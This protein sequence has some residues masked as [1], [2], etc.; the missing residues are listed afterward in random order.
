MAEKGIV[1][2]KPIRAKKSWVLGAK[3]KILRGSVG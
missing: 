1:Q 2:E 3:I